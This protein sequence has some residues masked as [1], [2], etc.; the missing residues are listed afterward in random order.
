MLLKQTPP[1]RRQM[2]SLTPLIDVVFILLLFFMLSS[3]FMQWRQID[4]S[5]PSE[6][7]TEEQQ[8][9]HITLLSNDGLVQINDQTFLMTDLQTLNTIVNDNSN[10]VFVIQ[11][12]NG[13]HI[14]SM[15][16]LADAL[17]TAGAKAVTLAGIE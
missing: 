1:Q 5:S 9:T 14:Q 16:N 8:L 15:I 11:V 4:V 6:S 13:L 17:K 10:A 12:E 2:I 3:T 7:D